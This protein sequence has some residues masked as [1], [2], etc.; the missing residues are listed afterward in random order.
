MASKMLE[1]H[2]IVAKLKECAKAVEKTPTL[3]QFMA[4]GVSRR[5]IDIHGGFNALVEKAGLEPNF[6]PFAIHEVEARAPKILLFDIETSAL[7]ALTWGGYEQNIGANQVI[8]DWYVLS[9]AAKWHGE[10]KVHYYD[11]RTTTLKQEDK[12]RKIIGKIHEI[13]SQADIVIGHNSDKFDIKKINARFIYYGLPAINHYKSVDTLK[14]ARKHFKF[15]FN[16]LAYLAKYLKVG[17][18]KSEHKNFPGMELWKHCMGKVGD[19]T[20]RKLAF[21][22]MQLYN[23]KDVT[24]LE[25]IYDKLAPYEPS[26]KFSSYHQMN[27]CSCG[28]QTFIKDGLDYTAKGIYQRYRCKQ[29][30]KVFRDRSNNL[31]SKKI[32]KGIMK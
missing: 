6:N 22:E 32:R 18:E 30:S 29:C 3:R 24:V 26:L 2:I 12:D 4:F 11:V 25:K 28:C 17:D 5:N 8:E 23:E 16:T 20:T 21:E 7:E 27:T 19:K 10:D 14:L 9:W 1:L 31:L 15:T 13:L